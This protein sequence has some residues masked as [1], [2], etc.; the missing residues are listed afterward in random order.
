[1]PDVWKTQIS[2]QC[3]QEP[4]AL[5]VLSP[6]K[7]DLT[8]LCFACLSDCGF[9]WKEILRLS[10]IRPSFYHRYV[11]IWYSIFSFNIPCNYRLFD[12]S[13][14]EQANS[15]SMQKFNF[16]SFFKN[17]YLAVPDLSCSMVDLFSCGIWDLAPWPGIK[18]G[19]PTLGLLES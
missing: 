7:L 8:F 10:P 15:Q 3:F 4:A 12:F 2:F 13:S 1:M 5:N 6:L 18:P 19:P 17:M 14:P 11:T 16:S 9:C